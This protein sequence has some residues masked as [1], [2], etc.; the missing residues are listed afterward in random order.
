MATPVKPPAPQPNLTEAARQA[1]AE[2]AAREAAD[3]RANLHRRK[4]QARLRAASEPEV[5]E[6]G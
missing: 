2:R 4:A 6:Q 3:L 5:P 1:A